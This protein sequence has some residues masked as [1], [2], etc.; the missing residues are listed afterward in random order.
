VE[1]AAMNLAAQYPDWVLFMDD[2]RP[3]RAAEALGLAPVS[4]PSYIASLFARQAIDRAT[5]LLMLAR[6]AARSTLN[7]ELIATGVSQIGQ[8]KMEERE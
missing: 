1:R 6:L 5:A 2:M 3:F 4:S 7:A 8:A